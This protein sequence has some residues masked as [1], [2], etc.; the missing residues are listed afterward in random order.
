MKKIYF[1]F[2]S[3][4]ICYSFPTLAG[5]WFQKINTKSPRLDV[6]LKSYSILKLDNSYP[7]EVFRKKESSLEFFLPLSSGNKVIKLQSRDIHSLDFQVLDASGRNV[8]DEVQFPLHYRSTR[9]SKTRNW[10]A[11]SLFSDGNLTGIWA[12]E[13]GNFNLVRLPDSLEVAGGDYILFNDRDLKFNNPFQC[14]SEALPL[15]PAIG[16]KLI[17]PQ[18]PSVQN[19]TSCKLTDIYWECDHDMYV[20]GGNSIQGAL[21]SFEA[22][23]NGTAIL[24]ENEVVNIGIKAVKVWNTPDPYSYSSSFTALDDFMAAGNAANWPGQLAHLLSTRNLNLGGV[25]YLNAIC[26]NFR[27]GFSNIDFTF[28]PLPLYSWTISTI[29]HEL[30]H[31]FSSPHTHNCN[32]EVSPGV[33]GQID[34]CWNAEGGCQ[35]IIRGRVGTIMSYCHLTGSVNLALGFGLLPANRLRNAFN[36]MSCV[37]GTVVIPPYSPSNSGPFCDGNTLTL[38]AEDL[39]GFSY[40]WTGPNGF[41]ASQREVQL[42]NATANDAGFYSLSV[43]KGNCE[44]RQKRTQAVFNCMQVGQTPKAFCAGARVA[45]PF[46]S[47]GT[48]NQGNKFILQISNSIGLFTNPITLD[49]I[50]SQVPETVEA[51][52]PLNLTLGNG[53]KFRFLSTNP[54]YE[55]LPGEKAITINPV[56]SSPS[57]VSASR[58]GPGV[59]ELT[60]QGGTSLHWYPNASEVIPVGVGRWFTTPPISQTTSYFVQSGSISV[61]K[62]GLGKSDA[63][64]FDSVTNGLVFDVLAGLRLDSVWVRVK[65]NATGLTEG[66][67]TFQLKKGGLEFFSRQF[68]FSVNPT[69]SGWLKVP[70][71]WRIDP[72]YDYEIVCLGGSVKLQTRPA[73]FPILVNGV[74]AIKGPLNGGNQEYPYFFEWIYNRFNSCPSR[75]IEVVAKILNGATPPAPQLS[76]VNQDSL[77]CNV[78]APQYEW[79]ISNQLFSNFGQKIQG[80]LNLTYQVRYK[81][82]S[83]WSDWSNPLLFNQTSVKEGRQFQ[84]SVS[85]NPVSSLLQ[86]SGP[87]AETEISMFDLQG[88]EVFRKMVVGHTLFSV[89]HLPASV[90]ALRWKSG[91][92]LGVIRVIKAD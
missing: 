23:F 86:W 1:S 85:P 14:H 67:L 34:S 26:T 51:T 12:S 64:T 73:S 3:L 75:K 31:N 39:S 81:L 17:K 68:S 36:N 77:L 78:A 72:G 91:N 58:C 27:Y 70:L 25:A 38:T 18:D 49:T 41:L 46:T 43:K 65:K 90:Y 76:F 71:F 22:M 33:F 35:P 79:L 82:D 21:N 16:E 80:L 48:F 47:T 74:L 54:V 60:A 66:Q 57:P 55:G 2:L 9:D 45:V 59:L 83:C 15:V 19:D 40:S 44:S 28:N 30:G 29:A 37:S 6:Y 4:L 24:F 69:E 42:P 8:N 84:V 87:E 32:W 92:Q 88:K 62:T 10:M 53:Y 56:G 11:L 20:K 63:T 89:S 61:G 52:L 13:N 50:T 7:L 5:D